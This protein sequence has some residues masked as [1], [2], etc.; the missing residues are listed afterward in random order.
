M[1]EA[2]NNERK[3]V[4]CGI[5][6]GIF[7]K[8]LNMPILPRFPLYVR[9]KRGR[10]HPTSNKT[11]APQLMGADPRGRSGFGPF[12]FG[13]RR[14]FVVH[15]HCFCYGAGTFSAFCFRCLCAGLDCAA[16][17]R[18]KRAHVWWFFGRCFFVVLCL[19]PLHRFPTSLWNSIVHRCAKNCQPV[20]M[21][22]P[23]SGE[24]ASLSEV[25]VAQMWCGQWRWQVKRTRRNRQIHS[26]VY[27]REWHI[28]SSRMISF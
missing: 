15:S 1:V 4:F 13:H 27:E 12:C 14:G 16:E 22:T 25:K 19:F 17:S 20:R 6:K 10:A 5:F 23:A 2:Y 24:V 26:L 18:R 3:I 11:R 7:S 8:L 28:W 21:R 9:S